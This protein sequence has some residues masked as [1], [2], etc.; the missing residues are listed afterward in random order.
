MTPTQ[1]AEAVRLL[2]ACEVT[3]IAAR[4]GVRRRQVYRMQAPGA[5]VPEDIAGRLRDAM[6]EHIRECEAWLQGASQ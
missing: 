6:R 1:F 4:L 3:R 2:A 5:A